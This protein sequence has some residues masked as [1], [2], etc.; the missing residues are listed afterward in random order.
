MSRPARLIYMLNPPAEGAEPA[1]SEV[2]AT[3]EQGIPIGWIMCFGGRNFWEPDDKVID[4][5]GTS[6]NRDRYQT[7]LEVADARLIN[8]IEVFRADPHLWVWF[9]ALEIHRRRL[10]ARGKNGFIRLE[11]PWAFA[12]EKMRNQM[13]QA[14]PQ[15]ENYVN[16][17]STDRHALFQ[18]TAAVFDEICPFVPHWEEGDERR[19]RKAKACAGLDDAVRAAAMIVGLPGNDPGAFPRTVETQ[20]KQEFL[21]LGSLPPYPKPA[22]IEK[23]AQ[24]PRGLFARLR[25]KF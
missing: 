4:R 15:A 1:T 12:T 16:Y 14:L 24:K 22:K 5:G 25:S 3:S 11:A 18:S 2:L 23:P 19:F 7:P 8:A 21:K 13:H 10:I 17:A 6:A 9:A 20:Y